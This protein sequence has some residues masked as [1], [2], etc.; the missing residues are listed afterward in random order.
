MESKINS[1]KTDHT[2]V[3]CAYKDSD[4]L[5]D[6]IQ[7][8]INQTVGSEIVISSSTPTDK[9]RETAQKYDIKLYE[10]NEGGSIGRDWNYGFGIPKT[11]YV[12][13]AHQDD[14]YLPEFAETNIGMMEKSDNCAIAFTNYAEIDEDSRNIK[15]NANLKIKDTML[16]PIKLFPNSIWM[17]KR[18]MSLGNPICCPA[19]TYNKQ[20]LNTFAFSEVLDFVVDW[21]ALIR[22]NKE[23][24][25][26]QY[27]KKPLLL[28][29]IHSGSETTSTI[30]SGIR[31]KEEQ[32]IFELFWPKPIAYRLAKI[33]RQS[34]KTNNDVVRCKN[35]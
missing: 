9:T 16:I 4:Y 17:R 18:I 3:I 8:I 12:T 27:N 15:R 10:H 22:I 32:Q 13:I 33:Y 21:D 30:A 11:K 29:R 34:E 5:E 25:R 14:I 6:C 24:T 2:F 35:D 23:K 1:K 20:L 19:I 26:W 7:S 31:A 28:H